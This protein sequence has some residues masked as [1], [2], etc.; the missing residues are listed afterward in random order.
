MLAATLLL[1]GALATPEEEIRGILERQAAAWNRGDLDDFM[2]TYEDSAETTYTGKSVIR[3]YRAILANY[4]QRYPT[5][6]AM[7]TVRFSGIEVRLLAPDA[8]LV[9]GRYELL[10]RKLGGHFT[11]VLRKTS[12]GW[13]IIHDQSS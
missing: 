7:D 2:T 12:S 1:L 9:L 4:R 5:R 10:S 11:L 8:A 6:E 13:K 3:G